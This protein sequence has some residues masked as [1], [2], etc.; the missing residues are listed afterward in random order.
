MIEASE[1]FA[2]E[3]AQIDF[4][5]PTV[6]LYSNMT[7]EPYTNDAAVLL[8]KQISNPVKWENIIRNMINSGIDTFIEIG[9]G[10]TLVNM[11]KKIDAKVKVYLVSEIDTVLAEVS[12]C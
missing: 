3:L 8:S 5:T 10:K 4:S 11:I 1:A 12:G 7:A 2:K 6:R 9:P